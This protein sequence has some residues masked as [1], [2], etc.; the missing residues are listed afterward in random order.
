MALDCSC[1]RST[2]PWL[3]A[4]AR[5]GLEMLLMGITVITGITVSAQAAYRNDPPAARTD[6]LRVVETCESSMRVVSRGPHAIVG[7]RA[8]VSS[9]GDS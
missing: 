5:L 9:T 4:P 7:T 1:V 3:A 6:F 2:L 8:V